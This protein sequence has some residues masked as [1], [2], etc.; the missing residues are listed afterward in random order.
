MSENPPTAGR[1]DADGYAWPDPRAQLLA[2][3]GDPV[4]VF[5]KLVREVDAG[6]VLVSLASSADETKRAALD[7]LQLARDVLADGLEAVQL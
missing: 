6:K 1:L 5:S 7:A 4:V 3:A 2:D